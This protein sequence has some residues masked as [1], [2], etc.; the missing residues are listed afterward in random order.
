MEDRINIEVQINDEWKGVLNEAFLDPSFE[1]IRHFLRREIKNGKVIYPPG[2]FIFHAFNL[3][4]FSKVKVVILGQDPYHGPGQAHGL[5]FSV[6]HG[7]KPPPS[8]L[9]IFKELQSDIGMEK[10]LHGNLETWASQGVFLLNSMLTV[11]YN[12]PG[13]HQGIGW[14]RFTDAAIKNLS[15]QR[16]HLV[17]M[18]WG[19]FAQQ[20]EFLI[21]GN[22]H[23]ILKAAHPSPFSAHRG[24]LGCKHFSKANQYLVTHGKSPIVWSL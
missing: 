5:S 22:K 13:S 24:F 7:V 9:N 16:E 8:L 23:L 12:Q 11:E 10:P 6:P 19:A 21:N 17:F 4:P 3:T 15:D 2:R 1:G 18:L 20:K 14:Q